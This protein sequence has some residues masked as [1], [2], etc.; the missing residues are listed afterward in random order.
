MNGSTVHLRA[1]FFKNN[2]RQNRAT[3]GVIV[4]LAGTFYTIGLYDGRN[5]IAV[6]IAALDQWKSAHEQIVHMDA[7]PRNEFNLELRNLLVLV[8]SNQ[9]AIRD[10]QELLSNGR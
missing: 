1:I 7:I 3:I 5:E 6:E 2:I 9:T 8:H 10:I 4:T